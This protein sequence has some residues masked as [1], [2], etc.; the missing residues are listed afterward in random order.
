MYLVHMGHKLSQVFAPECII[1]YGEFSMLCPLYPLAV[2]RDTWLALDGRFE[3]SFDFC[4]SPPFT[5]ITKFTPSAFRRRVH[6]SQRAKA[7]TRLP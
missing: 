4:M 7:V 5:F 3:P 6:F 1:G 2:S